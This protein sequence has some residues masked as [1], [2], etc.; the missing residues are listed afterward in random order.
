MSDEMSNSVFCG[1]V[2]IPARSWKAA[3]SAVSVT[4]QSDSRLRRVTAAG[5]LLPGLDSRGPIVR[6]FELLK[7]KLV[8]VFYCCAVTEDISCVIK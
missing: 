4:P 1:G 2:H 8:G 5:G 7:Q 6:G 3:P